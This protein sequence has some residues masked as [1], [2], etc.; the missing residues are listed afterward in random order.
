MYRRGL[1]GDLLLLLQSKTRD[2]YAMD[3]YTLGGQAQGVV[4]S[5]SADSSSTLFQASLQPLQQCASPLP[6]CMQH[7]WQIAQQLARAQNAASCMMA[8]LQSR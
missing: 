4:R 5:D 1:D 8:E 6:C 3:W 2:P 7:D